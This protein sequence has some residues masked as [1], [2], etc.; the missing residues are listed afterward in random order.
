MKRLLFL[1][2]WPLSLFAQGFAP[3]EL[4][5]EALID[6]STTLHVTRDGIYWRT[7]GVSKP[8]RWSGHNEPT[9]VNGAAWMPKWGKPSQDRGHDRSE[10]YRVGL[11]TTDVE[12]EVLAIGSNRGGTAKEHRVVATK[13]QGNEF[14]VTITDPEPDAR[15]YRFVVRKRK[16]N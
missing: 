4:V 8:G 14:V 3:K 13:Q 6:G 15:W 5:I 1:A 12:F 11:G 10:P 16:T 7:H 2:L 9:Y